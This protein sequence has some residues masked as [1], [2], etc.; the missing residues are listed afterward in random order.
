MTDKSFKS[1]NQSSYWQ[2]QVCGCIYMK[3]EIL[4]IAL[5]TSNAGGEVYGGAAC[6]N[7]GTRHLYADIAAREYDMIDPDELVACAIANRNETVWD[8][9]RKKWLHKGQVLHGSAKFGLRPNQFDEARA[10]NGSLLFF[11]A[12]IN[13]VIINKGNIDIVDEI[14]TVVAR[15]IRDRGIVVPCMLLFSGYDNDPRPIWKIPEIRK[16]CEKVY[17]KA[18]HLLTILSEQTVDPFSWSLINTVDTIDFDSHG[19]LTEINPE[20]WCEVLKRAGL[21]CDQFLRESGM[22]NSSVKVEEWLASRLE[23][24]KSTLIQKP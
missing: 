18:P 20:E 17:A 2:C 16:W 24:V 14:L 11:S 12:H 8:D 6:S 7:C 1:E 3:N 9:E 15:E 13:P 10:A 4:K 21:A 22:Q 5:L 23:H 19:C